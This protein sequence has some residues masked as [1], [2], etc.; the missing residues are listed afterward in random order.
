M[1]FAAALVVSLV[2]QTL[3]LLRAGVLSPPT[4]SARPQSG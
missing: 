2:S 1:A 3:V 4:V